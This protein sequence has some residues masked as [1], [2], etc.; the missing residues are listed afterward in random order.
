ME[1]IHAPANKYNQLEQRPAAC[2]GNQ[3]WILTYSMQHV[4]RG[5]LLLDKSSKI[6]YSRRRGVLHP[7]HVVLSGRGGSNTPRHAMNNN[8][9]GAYIEKPDREIDRIM[10]CR[11]ADK[12]NSVGVT[13]R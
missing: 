6:I 1:I 4:A 12:T 13:C 7:S 10:L 11:H 8:S 5:L 2:A 3:F 9:V